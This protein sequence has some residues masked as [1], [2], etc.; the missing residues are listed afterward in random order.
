MRQKTLNNE[1]W[2]QIQYDLWVCDKETIVICVISESVTKKNWISMIPQTTRYELRVLYNFSRR[3][4]GLLDPNLVAQELGSTNHT[5]YNCVFCPQLTNHTYYN[6]FSPDSQITQITIVFCPRLTNHT[7][8]N[9]LFVS[10][11][12]N[13][14][15]N[16]CFV[17]DSKITKITLDLS[18]AFV[19]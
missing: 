9:C 13:T 4:R 14:N 19:V 12:Q 1:S 18:L 15:Y 7:N 17:P 3:V 5:N 8:Y 2:C 10:E 16:V 11:S 6:C